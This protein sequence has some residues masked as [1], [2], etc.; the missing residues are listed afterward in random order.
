MGFSGP[1]VGLGAADRLRPLDGSS[2]SAWGSSVIGASDINDLVSKSGFGSRSSPAAADA[3]FRSAS[4][5]RSFELM[6]IRPLLFLPC[7][8]SQLSEES[9]LL[10][11]LCGPAPGSIDK[12]PMLNASSP[13][14]SLDVG[15]ELLNKLFSELDSCLGDLGDVNAEN[16]DGGF[17]VRITGEVADISPSGS[18]CIM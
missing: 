14:D 13:L 9:F 17:D 2:C 16:P 5:I 15:L 11:S 12:P 10:S 1:I 3:R 7:F 18:S 6:Y 8:L 4:R